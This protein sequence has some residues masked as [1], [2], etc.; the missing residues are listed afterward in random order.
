MRYFRLSIPVLLLLVCAAIFVAVQ[1]EPAG[2]QGRRPIAWQ[3]KVLIVPVGDPGG[4]EAKLQKAGEDGWECV[5]LSFS[6]GPGIR[7]APTGYAVMKR[8]R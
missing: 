1:R 5:C 6:P 2:A 8:Q 3:H 7:S 4:I